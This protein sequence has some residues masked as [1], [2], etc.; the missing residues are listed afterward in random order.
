MTLANTSLE[1]A[2]ACSG[3][4]SLVSLLTLSIVYGY[5]FDRRNWFRVLLAVTT[6]PLAILTNGLR[7]A[8]TGIAAHYYGSA[9]AEGFFHE[10]SGFIVFAAALVLLAVVAKVGQLV[11]PPST[12][13]PEPASVAVFP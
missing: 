2:E 12:A 5:F 8:G 10:F 7:V 3:I 6:I 13:N 1:V 9:A 11:W 4:R